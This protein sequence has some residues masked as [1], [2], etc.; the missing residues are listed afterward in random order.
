MPLEEAHQLHSL[1]TLLGV[2]VTV[3]E[4]HVSLDPLWYVLEGWFG[5]STP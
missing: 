2:I 5:Q 1:Y 3:K 4:K